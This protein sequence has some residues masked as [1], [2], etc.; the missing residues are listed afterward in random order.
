MSGALVTATLLSWWASSR[1]DGLE[2]V[3]TTTGFAATARESAVATGPF[4]GYTTAF[5]ANPR[6]SQA[7]AGLIGCAITFG[8]GWLLSRRTSAASGRG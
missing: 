7:V 6:L 8:L 3:A 1:P 2:H 4:A 5:V